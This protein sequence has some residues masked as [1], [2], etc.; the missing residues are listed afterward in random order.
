MSLP[1]LHYIGK[2]SQELKTFEVL[3]ALW[4]PGRLTQHTGMEREKNEI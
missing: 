3:Q 1:G 2:R 4:N